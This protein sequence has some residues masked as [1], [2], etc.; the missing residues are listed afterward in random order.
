MGRL[1][2]PR[3]LRTDLRIGPGDTL[4]VECD[5][6]RGMLCYAKAEN[7]FDVLVEHALADRR[8]G[9]TR[10]LRDF[11]AERDIAGDAS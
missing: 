8:A 6:E 1:T 2:I 10:H 4:F 9:R 11:G 5:E 3:R 7:P